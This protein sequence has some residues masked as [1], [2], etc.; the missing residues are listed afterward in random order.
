MSLNSSSP[1]LG[2]FTKILEK[3]G[4]Q[5][6]SHKNLRLVSSAGDG[7]FSSL[8]KNK[9]IKTYRPGHVETS[10]EQNKETRKKCIMTEVWVVEEMLVLE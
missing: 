4:P 5:T 10:K 6:N 8:S 3:K 7:T 1:A 9:L 2:T